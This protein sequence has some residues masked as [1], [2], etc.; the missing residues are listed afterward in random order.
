[1]ANPEAKT[2]LDHMLATLNSPYTSQSRK[3]KAAAALLPYLH[4]R[5][6][7]AMTSSTAGQGGQ[8]GGA[9]ETSLRVFSVPR[10]SFIDLKTGEIVFPPGVEPEPIEPFEGTHDW[11]SSALTDQRDYKRVELERERFETIEINPP[12]NVTV[13]NPHGR[14]QRDDDG[15]PDAA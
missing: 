10:G 11:T 1:M 7:A 2:P 3:D 9:S 15:G 4:P 8:P 14:R 12:A 6:S 5:L 13:L